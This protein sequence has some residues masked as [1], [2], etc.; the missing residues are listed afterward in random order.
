MNVKYWLQAVVMDFV[1]A[2]LAYFWIATDSEGALRLLL[3]VM[4]TLSVFQLI[5]AFGAKAGQIRKR[6][7]GFVYY[8]TATEVLF[9]SGAVWFGYIGLAVFRIFTVILWEG[10]RMAR[11]REVPVPS[12]EKEAA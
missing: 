8:H 5:G 6:P 2:G 4:W 12:T 7:K 11:A 3:F 10:A 1:I 9:I